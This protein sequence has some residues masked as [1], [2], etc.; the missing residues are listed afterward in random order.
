MSRGAQMHAGRPAA[1]RA[2]PAAAMPARSRATG[3]HPGLVEQTLAGEVDRRA[4]GGGLLF[5]APGT[6]ISGR[7]W[8]S[9]CGPFGL[10]MSCP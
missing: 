4:A 9:P 1:A 5:S 2:K 10:R 8:R 7:G 6:A 3:A